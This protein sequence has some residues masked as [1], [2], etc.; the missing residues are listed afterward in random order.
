V[1]SAEVVG[2][3]FKHANIDGLPLA[4]AERLAE[5]VTRIGPTFSLEVWLQ[6]SENQLPGYAQI[7]RALWTL[8]RELPGFLTDH[9]NMR[10]AAKVSSVRL[11]RL[12]EKIALLSNLR[13]TVEQI[14][15]QE[16]MFSKYAPTTGRPPSWWRH[17]AF[18]LAPHVR[19]ALMEAGVTRVG[20][21]NAGSPAIK[22][23]KSVFGWLGFAV[24]PD[25]IVKAMGGR[26]RGK[27]PA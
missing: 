14:L 26:K 5:E 17:W 10:A 22:I 2:I 24:S 11:P 4:A 13:G 16:G 15:V 23:M 8:Q 7:G 25:A 1:L 9:R 3:W 21:R 18:Y 6:N 20:F 27:K 12:S 19:G